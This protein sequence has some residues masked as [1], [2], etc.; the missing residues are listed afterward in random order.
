MDNFDI[1]TITEE[2]LNYKLDVTHQI[3]DSQKHFK[4]LDEIFM[5][6]E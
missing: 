1:R 3:C 6:K 4:K 2:E 5:R